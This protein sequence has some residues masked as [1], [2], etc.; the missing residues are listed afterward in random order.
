MVYTIKIVKVVILDDEEKVSNLICTLIEWDKLGLEP[1]G[2]ASDGIS[3]LELIKKVRPDLLI[4][5]IRM[6]GMSGLQLIEEAKKILPDL[7]VILI[8]GYSQFDYAQS[9]IRCG[10]VNYLL[11]PV[12][13]NELNDT[14]QKMSAE[15]KRRQQEVSHTQAIE[16]EIERIIKEK[17]QKALLSVIDDGNNTEACNIGLSF[18][19]SIVAVKVDGRALPY[20]MKAADVLVKRISD[21]IKDAAGNPS[22]CVSSGTYIVAALGNAPSASGVSE[23]LLAWCKEQIELFKTFTLT[24]ADGSRV[25]KE[26]DYYAAVRLAFQGLAER[27]ENG[28]LCLYHET[29]SVPDFGFDCTVYVKTIIAAVIQDDREKFTSTAAAFRSSV[30]D[31]GCTLYQLTET[32]AEF[33]NQMLE[34]SRLQLEDPAYR[35]VEQLAPVVEMAC[36]VEMLWKGLLLFLNTVYDSV[37]GSC[38]DRYVRPVREAQQY[39]LEHYGDSQLSLNGVAEYVG[40]NSNYFSGLFKKNC[41]IGFADYL[42]DLRLSKAKELL[43][44]TKNPVKQISAEV[45]YGDP[46]HFAKI[47]KSVTGIKPN[48]Y[49]QLY[50]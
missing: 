14:L 18:P 50:E 6:P 4:T 46:K 10:V 3:G 31:S 41:S 21:H 17:Q 28:T 11:K 9:A 1:A 16:E 2:T 48:E 7:Q 13:K 5:D 40:L 12:K 43:S 30:T 32:V 37:A 25:E 23:A 47:F 34:E 24:V 49:R 19:V 36:S 44:K 8:S 45:G 29:K 39:I 26:E 35:E 15:F 33:E 27:L 38:R 22:V 20:D 42:Q